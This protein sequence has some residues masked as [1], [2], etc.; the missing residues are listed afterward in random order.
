MRD[1]EF[2]CEPYGS[3]RVM[4]L[5]GGLDAQGN[6]VGWTRDVWSHPHNNG[7]T[8]VRTGDP[9]LSAC[10]DRNRKAATRAAFLHCSVPYRRCASG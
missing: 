8:R 6:V 10:G 9:R 5:S 4:K 1:D 3:L 7:V 2:Q